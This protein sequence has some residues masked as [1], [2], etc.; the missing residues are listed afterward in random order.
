MAATLADASSQRR[1]DGAA[2]A[3][4]V[5]ESDMLFPRETNHHHQPCALRHVEQP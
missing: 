5:E 4:V 2:T 1:S 3:P